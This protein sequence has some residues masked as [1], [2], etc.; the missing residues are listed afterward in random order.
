CTVCADTYAPG[1]GFSCHKCEGPA[2]QSALA[3]GGI[4]TAVVVTV[5]AFL[6]MELTRRID[7]EGTGEA[8]EGGPRT[9]K[10]GINWVLSIIA[11]SFPLTA[12]KTVIVVWQIV[13]QFAAIAGDT[14]PEVYED[15]VSSLKFINV[16]IGFFVSSSC[17]IRTNFYHRLLFATL[18]PIVVLLVLR[19]TYHIAK[20]RNQGSQR[21]LS[22]VKQKHLSAGLFIAFFI[23]SSVSFT[24]FQTFVCDTLDDGVSYLR[25]DYS[26]SCSA[27]QH[28]Y[29]VVFAVVMV[30]IYPVGIPYYCWRW[31]NWHKEELHQEDRD[32]LDTLKPFHSLWSAYK[33]SRYF[34]EI[35]EFGRRIT[36][37][38]IAVFVIPGSSAQIAIVL[39]LAVVFLFISESLSPFSKSID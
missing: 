3:I 16:D 32:S 13:T 14:Y 24:I 20:K 17:V 29:F 35:V 11:K 10:K 27:K 30:F 18:S 28:T 21:A 8:Q 4:V 39:L 33:P 5:T 19:R 38:G 1:L 31:L 12:F 26:Q 34:Y 37:T 7:D 6:L 25:A 9:C 23:Y 15:F 2:G 36:L 22:E